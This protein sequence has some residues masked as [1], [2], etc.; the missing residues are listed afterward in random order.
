[1]SVMKPALISRMNTIPATS[2]SLYSLECFTTDQVEFPPWTT[3]MTDSTTCLFLTES[4][5]SCSG[6]A[7]TVPS[8]TLHGNQESAK[9]AALRPQDGQTTIMMDFSTST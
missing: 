3:I 7:A 8:K 2:L 6:T 4:H 9:I 1:M 5:P